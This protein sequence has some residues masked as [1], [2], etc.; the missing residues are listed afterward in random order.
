MSCETFAIE[1]KVVKCL[2]LWYHHHA[3]NPICNLSSYHL[4]SP[5]ITHLTPSDTMMKA[6]LFLGPAA[7]QSNLRIFQV[8]ICIVHNNWNSIR[9]RSMGHFSPSV[10]TCQ[11][12]LLGPRE[13]TYTQLK[14]V[15]SQVRFHSLCCHAVLLL[16]VYLQ[17]IF[18]YS[19]HNIDMKY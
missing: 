5:A 1:H 15:I 16:F 12:Y 18:V 7:R 4:Q 10:L 14:R 11:L 8:Y 2:L 13:W 9:H 19:L 17:I 6:S 3:L